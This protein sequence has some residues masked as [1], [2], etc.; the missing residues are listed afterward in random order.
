MKALDDDDCAEAKTIV[1]AMMEDD[2]EDENKDAGSE[3]VLTEMFGSGE[4]GDHDAPEDMP[5]D[6][7]VVYFAWST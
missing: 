4:G 7:H 3:G 5:F 6:K 1:V 2:T